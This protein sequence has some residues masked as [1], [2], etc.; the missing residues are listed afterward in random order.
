[1][2]VVELML[3]VLEFVEATSPMLVNESQFHSFHQVFLAL[4]VF[5]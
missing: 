3:E 1:M 4:Y 2:K 5:V